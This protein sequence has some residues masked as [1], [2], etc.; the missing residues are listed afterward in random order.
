[1]NFLLQFYPGDKFVLAAANVLLQATMAIF[2]AW[3]LARFVFRHNAAIR[4][5][6]WLSALILVLLSPFTAY[7][8]DRAGLR[9]ITISVP[10]G[11]R[12]ESIA[13]S[14][15]DFSAISE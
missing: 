15:A 1:M 14:S 8:A 5:N 3:L 7:M 10:N 9:T 12:P 6:I 13:A 4:H 11:S 2:A